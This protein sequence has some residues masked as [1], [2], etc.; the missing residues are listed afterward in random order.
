[1]ENIHHL[2][3]FGVEKNT[4]THPDYKRHNYQTSTSN[5]VHTLQIGEK[6]NTPQIRARKCY[7]A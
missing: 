3:G 6:K 1:M 4:P 5:K 7:T 2:L